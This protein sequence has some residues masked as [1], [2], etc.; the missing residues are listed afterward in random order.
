MVYFNWWWRCVLSGFKLKAV[1]P[2]KFD[3]EIQHLPYRTAERN[4]QFT[5]FPM[6]EEEFN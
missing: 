4:S 5:I 1:P 2:I 6:L 3:E